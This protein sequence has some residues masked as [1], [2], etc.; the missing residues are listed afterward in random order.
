MDRNQNTASLIKQLISGEIALI[1]V[2]KLKANILNICCDVFV[3]NSQFIMMFNAR[4]T[5]V[6]YRLTHVVS[7]GSVMTLI[8]R[9]E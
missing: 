2:S 7:Q 8:R 1:R 3:H 4:I 9:G 6:I 5:A